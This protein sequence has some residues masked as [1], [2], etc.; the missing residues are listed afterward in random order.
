M[1]RDDRTQEALLVAL[2]DRLERALALAAGA[3]ALECLGDIAH[4][5]IETHSLAHAGALLRTASA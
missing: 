1:A 4:L 3:D 2:T 5:A